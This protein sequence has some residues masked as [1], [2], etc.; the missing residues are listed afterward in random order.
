M[1]M[2][3]IAMG[4]LVAAALAGPAAAQSGMVAVGSAPGMASMAETVEVQGTITAIDAKTRVVQLK[5]ENGKEAN[6]TAGPEVRNFDQLKVGD[7]VTLSMTKVLTLELKKGSTAVVSRDDDAAGARAAPG[8][9]PGGV[10]GHKVTIIAEVMAKDADAQ[11]VTLQGP[12]Q[13]IDLPIKDPAQFALISVGDRVE[14]TYIEAVAV[15]V[16]QVKPQVDY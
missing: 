7:T 10:I 8:E 2:Y 9:Q 13:S 5:G 4:V 14:A 11:T 1:R 15:S 3:K 12:K 6:I 16:E